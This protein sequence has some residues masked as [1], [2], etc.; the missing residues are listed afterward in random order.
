MSDSF[1]LAYDKWYLARIDFNS[2][3]GEFKGYIDDKLFYSWQPANASDLIKKKLLVSIG[4]WADNGTI[5]TGY[6][7]DVRVMK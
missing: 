4:T 7:D 3:I 6:V 5:I 2:Q 1:Y